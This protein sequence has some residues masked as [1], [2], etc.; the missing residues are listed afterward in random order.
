KFVQYRVEDEGDLIIAHLKCSHLNRDDWNR[1]VEQT[2][3]VQES[4]SDVFG[5]DH[6]AMVVLRV[7]SSFN[8][9]VLDSPN[10]MA[11]VRATKLKLDLES[12]IVVYVLKKK[13]QPTGVGLP[14]FFVL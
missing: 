6:G 14:T 1:T 9:P 10:D 5:N 2:N 13:I 8:V 12:S 7:P 4:R 11:L 3:D